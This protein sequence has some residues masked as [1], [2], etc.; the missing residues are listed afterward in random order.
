[1]WE[2]DAKECPQSEVA[3]GVD[4]AAMLLS[5]RGTLLPRKLQGLLGAGSDLGGDCFRRLALPTLGI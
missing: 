4:L 2:A 5:R 3:L 1:M